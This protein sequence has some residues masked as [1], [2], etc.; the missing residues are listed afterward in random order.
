[1]SISAQHTL[2][3]TAALCERGRLRWKPVKD[4]KPLKA[5]L[6]KEDLLMPGFHLEP[7]G[8]LYQWD[9]QYFISRQNAMPGT[10]H[11]QGR[12]G[13]ALSQRRLCELVCDEHIAFV[14]T[15]AA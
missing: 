6:R 11:Y 14:R 4:V 5:E 8:G 7:C 12:V 3:H 10:H 15:P 9:G 2:G 1:M 13:A